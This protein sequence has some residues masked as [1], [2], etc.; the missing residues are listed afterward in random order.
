MVLVDDNPHFYVFNS[1]NVIPM[2]SYEGGFKNAELFKLQ[3]VLRR[4]V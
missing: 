2:K 1:S 3:K 4:S